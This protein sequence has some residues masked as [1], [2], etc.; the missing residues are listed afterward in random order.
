MKLFQKEELKILW[1]F[2]LDALLSPLLFFVAAFAIV[3]LMG[4]GFSLFQ[5]SIIW[6]AVPLSS[7]IFEIPTGAMADLYGRKFS[8]LLSAILTGLAF[9]FL[10]FFTNFYAILAAFAFIGFSNTLNSGAREAWVVDLLKGK[11]RRF[12]SGYF[13]KVKSIDSFSLIF[14]GI[15]GA[16]VVKVFGLL[17]IWLIGGASY[18]LTFFIL[19]FAKEDYV[20]GKINLK[21]VFKKIKKQ[22]K[23]SISY[24]R[25]HHVL[26]YFLIAGAILAF[27]EGLSTILAWTPL[28]Q[29]LGLKDY[30]F[31]YLWSAI[32]A[33]GVIA[34]LVY[35]RLIKKGREKRFIINS[36][37]LVSLFTMV[38]IFAYNLAFAFMLLLLGLFF[39]F[40][41]NP[42]ERMYF[43][44]FIPTKLRAT[45]GSVESML[46]SVIT[47]LVL[48]IAG[49]LID[50]IGPRYTIFIGGIIYL[51]AALIYSRIKD[52]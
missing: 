34:P 46:I 25:K 7:L 11:K 8:V 51:P 22:T 33:V 21:Q 48:P 31:G 44:R 40:L 19:V 13:A 29:D 15:L 1:P 27:A 43:H 23:V 52:K 9:L 20:K 49:L 42:A 32:G 39:M 50:S 47:L 16:F 36:I 28:L 38:M 10:F 3:Y 18:F 6:A 17:I 30:A 2:Y 35:Q 26:F 12:L 5:I 37:L 41:K 24:S 45:I 4:L 14:S